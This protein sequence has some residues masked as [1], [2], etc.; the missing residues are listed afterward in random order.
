MEAAAGF[1]VFDADVAVAG[2]E[3]CAVPPGEGVAEA[4]ADGVRD[5]CEVVGV[6][7]KGSLRS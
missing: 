7:L 3:P 6:G 4:V 1:V 2:V 5:S